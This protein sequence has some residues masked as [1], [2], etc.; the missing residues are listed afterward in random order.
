MLPALGDV[1]AQRE[2]LGLGSG[3]EFVRLT[4]PV[5]VPDE[6]LVEDQAPGSLVAGPEVL[7]EL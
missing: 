6:A 5:V 3:I 7:R 4:G 2:D 1:A